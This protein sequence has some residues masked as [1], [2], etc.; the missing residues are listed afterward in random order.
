MSNERKKIDWDAARQQLAQAESA[1][2]KA[3]GADAARIEEVYRRREAE[4]AKPINVL[5][6]SLEP[7]TY[8][9]P[10]AELTEVL[11]FTRCTPVPRAA[12]E[13]AGVINLRGELRSVIDLRRLLSVPAVVEEPGDCI[14]M[15]KNGNDA[16]G[17]KV[18]RVEKVQMIRE[19]ELASPEGSD[20]GG[21]SSY[22]KGLSPDKV[23]V[24][25]AAA[26]RLHPVFRTSPR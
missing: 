26:L 8:G 17:L 2:Q 18:G 9:L 15:F 24:L 1:L 4:M 10:I 25:D 21:S 6:F 13:I 7:E 23:I 16:V 22:F 12:A 20:A 11:P 14:L 19:D 3:L 5:V